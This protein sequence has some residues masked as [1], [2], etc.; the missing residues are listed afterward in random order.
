MPF[1]EINGFLF[2]SFPFSNTIT[3]GSCFDQ[4]LL[5]TLNLKEKKLIFSSFND[6]KFNSSPNLYKDLYAVAADTSIH[7]KIIINWSLIY[8]TVAK[9]S[10]SIED[11]Y[12]IFSYKHNIKTCHVCWGMLK[13]LICYYLLLSYIWIPWHINFSKFQVV[14]F[15]SKKLNDYS[16]M[17]DVVKFIN[18]II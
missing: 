10:K 7:H 12:Y 16:N 1:G 15:V 2:V 18:H 14:K 6:K 13:F 9:T 3:D 5:S 8:N 4:E 11:R 17:S